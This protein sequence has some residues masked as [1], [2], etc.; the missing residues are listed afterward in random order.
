MKHQTAAALRIFENRKKYDDLTIT[1]LCILD[2][3]GIFNGCGGK[4]GVS[5]DEILMMVESFEYFDSRLFK[6]FHTEL[7]EQC[8]I[9]DYRY[10]IG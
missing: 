8:K 4:G 7:R 1:E 3:E 10:W 6:I 2:E 5:F 9:H